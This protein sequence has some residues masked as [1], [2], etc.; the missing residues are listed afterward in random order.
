MIEELYACANAVHAACAATETGADALEALIRTYIGYFLPRLALHQLVNLHAIPAAEAK[1]TAE[2]LA[3]IRPINDLLYA[4]A[5]KRLLAESRGKRRDRARRQAFVAH[6]AAIGM[7]T[8]R[9]LVDKVRDPL[10][11]SDAELVDELVRTFRAGAEKGR[12]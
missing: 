12:P 3:R 4:E 10:I 7:L 11:H 8:M 2:Q 5:E 9:A 1:V 6:L